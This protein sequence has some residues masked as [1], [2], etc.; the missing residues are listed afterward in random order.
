MD[1]SSFLH[2]SPG[3]PVHD[4]TK[5]DESDTKSDFCVGGFALFVYVSCYR[6]KV[7]IRVHQEVVICVSQIIGYHTVGDLDPKRLVHG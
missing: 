3:Y 7:S 6:G 5:K 4:G 1:Y 2:P